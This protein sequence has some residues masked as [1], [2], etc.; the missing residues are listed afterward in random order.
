MQ[1]VSNHACLGKKSCFGLSLYH[2][3]STLQSCS[4]RDKSREYDTLKSERIRVYYYQVTV[5]ACPFDSLTHR[6]WLVIDDAQASDALTQ[7]KCISSIQSL[8][9]FL[10]TLN[11]SLTLNLVPGES[12]AVYVND[13]G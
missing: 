7:Y 10:K 11:S 13:A 12:I 4:G 1:D 5:S 3:P 6:L 2:S 8:N 9:P